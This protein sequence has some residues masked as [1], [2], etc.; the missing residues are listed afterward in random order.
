MGIVPSSDSAP[1]SSEKSLFLGRAVENGNLMQYGP[2]T[3]DTFLRI[4]N[5]IITRAY[6]N[7]NMLTEKHW[8]YVMCLMNS[9]YASHVSTE[10]LE[11]YKLLFDRTIEDVNSGVVSALE[12]DCIWVM[13]FATH[14]EKYPEMIK[15]I[16]TRPQCSDILTN[17]ITS[18]AAWSYT[19]IIGSTS[20]D[21]LGNVLAFI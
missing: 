6:D 9:E 16:A 15:A 7:N 2:H 10:N 12:L 5:D 17:A 19:N 11:Q 20:P 4:Y 13:W 21:K 18:A 14:N 1:K 3:I 8:I